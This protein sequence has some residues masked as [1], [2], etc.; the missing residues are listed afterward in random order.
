[1]FGPFGAFAGMRLFH[2]KTRKNKFLLVPAFLVIHFAI[3]LYMLYW[4]LTGVY[5]FT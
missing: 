3:I 5:F 2:H 1:V 4:M